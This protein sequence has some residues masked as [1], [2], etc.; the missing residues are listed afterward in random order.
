MPQGSP[1]GPRLSSRH[2][3]KRPTALGRPQTRT[4]ADKSS[5]TKATK[6][7]G[8]GEAAGVLGRYTGRPLTSDRGL[9]CFLAAVTFVAAACQNQRRQIVPSADARLPRTDILR[10]STGTAPS[11]ASYMP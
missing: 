10:S 6:T 7:G 2:S 11:A 8:Q 9:P 5:Q 3:E 4:T 1:A